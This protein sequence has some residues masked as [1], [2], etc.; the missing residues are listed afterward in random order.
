[1][2]SQG[3]TIYIKTTATD[4]DLSSCLNILGATNPTKYPASGST[5][6]AASNLY[7]KNFMKSLANKANPRPQ[8]ARDNRIIVYFPT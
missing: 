8:F 6:Q 2:F 3:N 5:A 7:G 4:H 1:M